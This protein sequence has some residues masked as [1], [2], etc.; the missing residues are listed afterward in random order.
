M[1]ALVSSGTEMREKN[2]ARAYTNN[3]HEY[4]CYLLSTIKYFQNQ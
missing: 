3:V 2:E 4:S 1:N